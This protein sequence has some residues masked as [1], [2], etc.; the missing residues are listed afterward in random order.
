MQ[1]ASMLKVCVTVSALYYFV[2]LGV[3]LL[4]VLGARRTTPIKS[5]LNNTIHLSCEIHLQR[6]SILFYLIT[7]TSQHS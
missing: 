7:I 3:L 5:V 1:A 4:N 2:L 6:H